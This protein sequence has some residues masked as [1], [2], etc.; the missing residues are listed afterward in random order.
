MSRI[1]A[2]R[3][4]MGALRLKLSAKGHGEKLQDRVSDVFL[5]ID[6]RKDFR[7]AAKSFRQSTG[8]LVT[9]ICRS[10][11]GLVRA[12]ITPFCQ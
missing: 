5:D 11:A 9:R 2:K 6:V 12:G 4:N 3:R 10:D 7:M 8:L 1:N